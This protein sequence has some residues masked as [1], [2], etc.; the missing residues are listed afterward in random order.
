M[1][2]L[3]RLLIFL[4][5]AI[6]GC[7]AENEASPFDA[8]EDFTNSNVRVL[9]IDSLSV[10]MTTFKFDSISTSDADR[11]LVGQYEDEFFGAT[12]SSSF[13]EMTPESYEIS[14][15]AELDSI[16]LVLGYDRYY[17]NDTT[18]LMTINV[19]KLSDEVRA[20]DGA[21]YNTSEIAFDPMP[22]AS[23]TVSPRPSEDSLYI[24]IPSY[25]LE[26]VFESIRE[27]NI[28]DDNDLQ[29]VLKGFT[30]QAAETDNAAVIG[31]SKE[32]TSTYLRFFYS[33]SDD[34]DDNNGFD[35]RINTANVTS[36]NNISSL[37]N[38]S[39]L[40]LL[41]DQEV[42]L[43]SVESDDRAY[44]QSGVGIATRIQFPSVKDLLDIPGDGTILSATLRVQPTDVRRELLPIRDSINVAIVDQNNEVARV[45]ENGLGQVY[46]LLDEE[47]EEFGGAFY[48]ISVGTYLEQKINETVSVDDAIVIFGREYNKTVDRTILRGEKN[49]EYPATLIVTYAAY[50]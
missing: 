21:F 35:I 2:L 5:I 1:K 31:F 14:D 30:L 20:V 4:V 25:Y 41:I 24:S 34:I 22:I 43:P 36:F 12:R 13:F 23:I 26:D 49:E 6:V 15:D 9:S 16:G 45:L 37:P 10:V 42:N 17:Y 28:D 40:D 38:A 48:D 33:V 39:G 3:R 19:H 44:M 50:E 27:N 18:Q 7:E 32:A 46:A 47:E 29:Q 8:G 11:L